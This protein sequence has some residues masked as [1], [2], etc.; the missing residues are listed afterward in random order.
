MGT[1]LIDLFTQALHRLLQS[2]TV[3]GWC[4]L[5]GMDVTVMPF[6]NENLTSW[7]LML[8]SFPLMLTL[9][10]FWRSAPLDL[11]IKYILTFTGTHLQL[12]YT[13]AE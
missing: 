1:I 2:D 11:F 4:S 6:L 8:M 13:T 3:H 5:F 7:C 10:L 12:H 9:I